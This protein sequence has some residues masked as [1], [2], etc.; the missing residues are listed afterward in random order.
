VVDIERYCNE[1]IH[2]LTYPQIATILD[3]NKYKLRMNLNELIKHLGSFNFRTINTR[4]K[5]HD[6]IQK[7]IDSVKKSDKL[8][9]FED[10][11]ENLWIEERYEN[12]EISSLEE[13]KDGLIEEISNMRGKL[14]NLIDNFDL[15]IK[16]EIVD[17]RKNFSKLYLGCTSVCPF[18]NSKCNL[19]VDHENDHSCFRHIYM[20]FG[21]IFETSTH[22]VWIE[23]IYCYQKTNLE[24]SYTNSGTEFK[25]ARNY[26]KEMHPKWLNNI[27]NM[28]LNF[29]NLPIN[30]IENSNMRS[31][32]MNTR[33]AILKNFNTLGSDIKDQPKYPT[34]W[35]NLED[36]EKMLKKDHEPMWIIEK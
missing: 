28:E 24:S 20:G 19:G 2:R 7:I 21:R 34:E 12:V 18:C 30:N 5:M 4:D 25:T 29:G 8:K 23:E 17:K 10:L 6:V 16:K 32:W 33:K 13:F 3:E 15:K 36:E 31:A 11:F 14:D 22:F 27:E 1:I 26:L 35:A 9:Y